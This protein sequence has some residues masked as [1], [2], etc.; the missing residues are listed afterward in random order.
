LVL[1]HALV[2]AG[3]P[4]WACARSAAAGGLLYAALW[5]LAHWV[6]ELHPIALVAL[7]VPVYLLAALLTGAVRSVQKEARASQGARFIDRSS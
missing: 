6:P 3:F 4:L 2:G 7:G 5:W 1:G